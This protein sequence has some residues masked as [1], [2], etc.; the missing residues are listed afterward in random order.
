MAGY[1]SN[2]PDGSMGFFTCSSGS[3]T[4]NVARVLPNGTVDLGANYATNNAAYGPR[5]ATS[6]TG[7]TGLY[8]TDGR[9]SQWKQ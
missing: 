3:L 9:V 6:L 1:P 5:C 7:R 4:R 2:A 8:Y